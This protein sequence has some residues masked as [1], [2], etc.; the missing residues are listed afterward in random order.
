[1]SREN[2]NKLL[3][4]I[5]EGLVSEEYVITTCLKY[6]SE[7]DVK[8]MMEANEIPTVDEEEEEL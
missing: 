3:E 5:E 4:M 2:T 6:M 8:D 1:M 7:D